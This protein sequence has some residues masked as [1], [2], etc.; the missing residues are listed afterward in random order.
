MSYIIN[1]TD[2]TIFAVVADGTINQSSSMTLVGQNYEDYG[3]FLDENFMHLLENSSN[4][5]APTAPITGQLWWDKGNNVLNIYNGTQFKT[6]A[7]SVASTSEPISNVTGDFWFDTS[8]Q[9]LKVYTGTSWL[10]VGPGYSSATG[11]NGAISDT[12]VDNVSGSHV[13]VRIYVNNA[14][15][16]IISKDAEFTPSSVITGFGNILPGFNLA[17]SVGAQ[18]LQYN[19]IAANA[20]TLNGVTSSQFLRSDVNATTTGVLTV[21]NDNGFLVG[22]NSNFK[23]NVS[24]NTVILSNQTLNAN[25]SLNVNVSGT[26]STALTVN[27]ATG[28]VHVT[29]PPVGSNDTTVATT[30]FVTSAVQS[31]VP[32]GVILLWS[33][34]IVSIP[35]GWYLCDGSNSTPDL[36]NR[37]VVGAGG[38]YAVGASGG[39]STVTLSVA[40]LPAHTHSLS[41][42][43]TTS[44]SLSLHNHSFTGTS[45]GQSQSHTHIATATSSVSDSGHAHIMPGDDQL[46]GAAGALWPGNSAGSFSY[47]ASSRYSGGAQY[48][49][50]SNANTGITVSTTVT[51]GNA[52]QDH[53]HNYGGVTSSEDLAH[54]HTWS[55]SGTTGSTGSGD[56]FGILPPYYALCYIMKG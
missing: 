23:A 20:A 25:L 41:I 12:I 28:K 7:A 2:G 56:S 48:W 35:T 5:V 47:D 15:V 46:N 45:T 11:L 22:Q 33:G 36:R 14:T 49:Y 38:S 24:S 3:A 30:A 53:T 13:V 31:G 4:D 9:Q 8:V 44:S 18:T 34:S 16:A 42:G 54:T 50:T 51:N 43:N 27:G 40:N 17:S 19:G 21:A 55:Y 26:S 39:A 6:F 52:N 29:A 10:V 37:F 1:L 32:S